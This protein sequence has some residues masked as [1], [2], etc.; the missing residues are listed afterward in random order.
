MNDL[1]TNVPHQPGFYGLLL[2][3]TRIDWEAG[4]DLLR[5]ERAARAPAAIEDFTLRRWLSVQTLR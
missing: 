4:G 2:R 1:I 5:E 3:L